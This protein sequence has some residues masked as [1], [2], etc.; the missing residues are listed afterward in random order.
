MAATVADNERSLRKLTTYLPLGTLFFFELI[1][2]VFIPQDILEAGECEDWEKIGTGVFIGVMAVLALAMSWV[3]VVAGVNGPGDAIGLKSPSIGV[4]VH[5]LLAPVAFLAIVV[6]GASVATCLFGAQL[7][8]SI[9]SLT[10]VLGL[11]FS[12]LIALGIDK[13]TTSVGSGLLPGIDYGNTVF[14]I[15]ENGVKAL[16]VIKVFA[17]TGTLALYTAAEEAVMGDASVV[18]CTTL[19][20]VVLVALVVVFGTMVALSSLI[21]VDRNAAQ[22]YTIQFRLAWDAPIK[23]AS[24][25]WEGITGLTAFLLLVLFSPRWVDCFGLNLSTLTTRIV[26]PIVAFSL[27]FATSIL[28]LLPPPFSGIATPVSAP[29]VGQFPD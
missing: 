18:S 21:K 5:S 26:P 27:L 3:G 15:G 19:Q 2:P 4:A 29:G 23:P 10:P 13:P 20:K 22:E 11:A 16:A 6:P 8:S 25:V 24:A 28:S 17:P 1:K 7:P 12:G 9:Q 14:T